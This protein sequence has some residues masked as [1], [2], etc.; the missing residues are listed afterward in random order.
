MAAESESGT[1]FSAFDAAATC[2]WPPGAD[3]P[4]G[5][6]VTHTHIDKVE[7]STRTSA[8]ALL[9]SITVTASLGKKVLTPEETKTCQAQRTP[10]EVP[11]KSYQMDFVFAGDGY[12]PTHSSASLVELFNRR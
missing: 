6:P 12:K 8:N 9:P 1:F 7:F 11:V 5:M 3:G 2:G 4:N 10:A